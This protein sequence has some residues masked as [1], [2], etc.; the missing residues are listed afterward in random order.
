MKKLL[1]I[2]LAMLMLLSLAACGKDKAGSGDKGDGG[3]QEIKGEYFDAG[4]VKALAPKG[5]KAFPAN[6]IFA[7]DENATDPD[8][9]TICKGAKDS[10][11]M[12]IKPLVRID[13]YGPDTELWG[14]LEGLKEW[15][16]DVQDLEPIVCDN[17]TWNGFTTTDYGL[18]AILVAVDGDTE[19]QA[20]VY[21]ET[22]GGNISL[23]DADVL[24]ILNSIKP[25]EK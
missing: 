14:G 21:L 18:M 23:E 16:T 9:I 8:V 15:Y 1:C 25:S 17:Y 13:Y 22:D 2:I 20:S 6:D 24:A 3:K 11:D 7:E 10:F 5:W 19:I 12:L 4:N